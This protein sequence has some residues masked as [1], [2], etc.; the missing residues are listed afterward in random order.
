MVATVQY[1]L[2]S[3]QLLHTVYSYL[4]FTQSHSP[5]F[6]RNIFQPAPAKIWALLS[7]KTMSEPAPGYLLIYCPKIAPNLSTMIPRSILWSWGVEPKP[8]PALMAL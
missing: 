4:M 3:A 2:H 6:C 5:T 8:A 7:V 1:T